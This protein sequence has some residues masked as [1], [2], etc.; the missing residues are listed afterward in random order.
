MQRAI[1]EYSFTNSA[2]RLAH[3]LYRSVT[4]F[5]IVIVSSVTCVSLFVLCLHA[6]VDRVTMLTS[7]L[8]V[9]CSII[10]VK[11]DLIVDSEFLHN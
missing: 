3:L 4:Q 7:G 8:V 11:N 6:S 10:R 1:G 2:V 5:R 9:T